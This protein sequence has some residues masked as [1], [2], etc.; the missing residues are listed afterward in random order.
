[1]NRLPML[2]RA[3]LDGLL[4]GLAAPGCQLGLQ[5]QLP[6]LPAPCAP[7]EAA[8]TAAE[9]EPADAL[10]PPRLA[11]LRPRLHTQLRGARP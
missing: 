8:A 2:M 11:R 7:S 4:R 3:G 6:R 9:T 1:M 10:I 5:A